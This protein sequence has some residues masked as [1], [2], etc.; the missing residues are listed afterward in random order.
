MNVKSLAHPRGEGSVRDR[1]EVGDNGRRLLAKQGTG[2]GVIQ[3]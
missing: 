2:N 3:F 1:P